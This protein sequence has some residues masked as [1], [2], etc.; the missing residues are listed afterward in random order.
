MV[1]APGGDLWISDGETGR[2]LHLD[3]QGIPLSTIEGLPRQL[4]GL[5]VDSRGRLLVV[6]QRRARVLVMGPDGREL[7]EFGSGVVPNLSEISSLA[8]GA[9]DEGCWISDS[10]QGR[11]IKLNSEG[12]PMAAVD[13]RATCS[14]VERPVDLTADGEGGVWVV[15]GAGGRLVRFGPGGV[16]RQ[17]LVPPGPSH[18]L[19][20]GRV[21]ARASGELALLDADR[22][23]ILTWD[24]V[25]RFS[26]EVAGLAAPEDAFGYCADLEIGPGLRVPFVHP[27]RTAGLDGERKC[28][29]SI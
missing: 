8:L 12:G 23:R 11:L 18:P 9:P 28:A 5:R 7:R 6:D 15:D 22:G 17:V 19:R 3:A 10:R 2:L 16:R 4:G 29:Q 14:G 20:N 21:R 24:A 26:G 1:V 25:H 13:L 27:A